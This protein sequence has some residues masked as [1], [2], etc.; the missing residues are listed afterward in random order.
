L[1][2]SIPFN[3]YIELIACRNEIS[4]RKDF[5]DGRSFHTETY[6]DSTWIQGRLRSRGT[7]LYNVLVHEILKV[8]AT[9]FETRRVDVRQVVGDDID[10][11]LLSVHAS[12]RCV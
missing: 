5:L 6:L 3:R 2:E 11:R 4:L 9:L 7:W 1:K 8:C 12:G 10:V